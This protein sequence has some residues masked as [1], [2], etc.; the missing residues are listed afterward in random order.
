MHPVPLS[1]SR[2][3]ARHQ[4]GVNQALVEM[5]NRLV[6]VGLVCIT[7]LRKL[8]LSMQSLAVAQ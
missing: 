1:R 8:L 4:Q 6:Q 2:A 7:N 5:L 3:R